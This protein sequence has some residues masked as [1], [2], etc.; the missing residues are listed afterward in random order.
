MMA[1]GKMVLGM[2]M[3]YILG[4][5]EAFIKVNGFRILFMDQENSFIKREIFMK[6]NGKMKW[7]MARVF[8]C[9]MVIKYIIYY[10]YEED[11]SMKV[12][13]KMIYKMALVQK[14]GLMVQDMM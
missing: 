10:H 9:I 5:M 2:E 1:N 4:L 7:P 12:N 13:G 6:V 14:F 3:V 11:L 8:M